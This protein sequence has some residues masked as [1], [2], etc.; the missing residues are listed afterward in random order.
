M[1]GGSLK[2]AQTAIEYLLL[3]ALAVVAVTAVAY[4]VKTI[5]SG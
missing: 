1:K 5:L 2:K 4:L 3:V